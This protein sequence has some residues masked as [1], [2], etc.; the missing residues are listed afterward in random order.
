MKFRPVASAPWRPGRLVA[1][2][3]GGRGPRVPP[4]HAFS[5]VRAARLGSMVLC[6]LAALGEKGS[7]AVGSVVCL[8]NRPVIR[9]EEDAGS[10]SAGR[11]ACG[12]MGLVSPDA[13]SGVRVDWREGASL[14][15]R[16]LLQE[17]PAAV[18]PR[19]SGASAAAG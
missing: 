3:S 7:H 17:T 14:F 4:W 13:E 8:F 18:R 16:P 1:L 9:A 6:G 12:S 5:L 15:W 10:R 11:H 2:G 19:G